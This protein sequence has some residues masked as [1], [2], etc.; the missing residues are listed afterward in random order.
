[1]TRNVNEFIIEML[2]GQQ[3]RFEFS[4]NCRWENLIEIYQEI[5]GVSQFLLR[6]NSIYPGSTDPFL[7][8][9]NG[10]GGPIAFRIFG[11]HKPESS[12]LVKWRKSTGQQ[13]I[14]DGN[15]IRIG[16]DDQ[17]KPGDSDF[18]NAIVLAHYV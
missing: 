16:Y 4:F 8:D 10:L 17:Y 18:M 2:P 7:T 5:N 3:I 14:V 6:R 9:R 15:T 11:L 13:R 1:M 12:P